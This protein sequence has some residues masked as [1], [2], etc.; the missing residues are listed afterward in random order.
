MQISCERQYTNKPRPDL[1]WECSTDPQ[2]EATS[3]RRQ[4]IIS[5]AINPKDQNS[6]T[7]RFP[8]FHLCFQLRNPVMLSSSQSTPS[9]HQ[10][11]SSFPN[12]PQPVRADLKHSL[13]PRSSF[14]TL[15]PASESPIKPGDGVWLPS[16][17]NLRV[18]SLCLFLFCWSS[19]ISTCISRNL[20]LLRSW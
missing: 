15:L 19:F 20:F 8:I 14:H 11:A 13:Y 4:T 17:S 12:H 2:S 9:S 16:F 10:A 6:K 1:M 5:I 3:S 18:K 7:A